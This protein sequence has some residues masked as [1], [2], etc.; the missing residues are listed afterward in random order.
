[1][2][3]QSPAVGN[4]PAGTDPA[5]A[6]NPAPILNIPGGQA[7]TQIP[8]NPNAYMIAGTT[9]HPGSSAAVVSGASY[10]LAPS[11]VLIIGTS[12]VPLATAAAGSGGTGALTA[13]NKVFTPL[14]S[15][16]NRSHRRHTFS[17]WFLLPPT[18]VQYFS[19]LLEASW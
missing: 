13:G 10:S 2:Q 15:N 12:T 17:K 4:S 18:T 6:T 9:L 14:G 3:I 1:M 7:L 5:S 11:G 19:S 16:G 8:S